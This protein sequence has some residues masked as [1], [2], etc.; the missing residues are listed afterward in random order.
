VDALLSQAKH[1]ADNMKYAFNTKSGVPHNDLLFPNSFEQGNTN[2]LAVTG[3]LILEWMRLSDLTG[4]KQYG[5]LA[6]RAEQYLLHPK[7]AS[8]EPWPGLVGSDI[9]INDGT[10]ANAH[11][12]WSGG[13]DSF[14]EYLI[15]MWVYDP[16][17]FGLYKD[18]WELAAQSSIK[19]L[20]SHPKPQLTF[21]A[22]WD[23]RNL[24]NYSQH[25]TCFD[26]G[27]FILGGS[28]LGKAEYLDFGLKLV[29]SCHYTYA[30][31]ATGIG[32]EAFSWDRN[33]V[34]ADQRAFFEKNGFWV[35]ASD[36]ILRPEVIESI[37]YAYRAT[38]DP[39]YQLWVW[40]AFLAFN[41]T[42]RAGSGF[43]EITNVNAPDGGA[44]RDNQESFWFAEVLKYSYLIFAE[45]CQVPSH[46]G[47]R[48][49]RAGTNR[50]ATGRY[51]A[52]QWSRKEERVRI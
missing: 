2:G 28:V 23:G 8:T 1:L 21:L 11:G 16:L 52:S 34:P 5:A 14:Y 35:T 10:F 32:P 39:K 33:R 20:A 19:Y 31:T 48:R 18:R 47:G 40:D 37:Y 17:R 9:S 29:E 41:K 27:N 44:K 6:D 4:D 22:Q 49:L 26:G 50:S 15:K 30:A 38:G 45:V 51:V 36:Y 43:S 25:L 42:V 3:T 24:Q 13:S 46:F 12:S 7:P